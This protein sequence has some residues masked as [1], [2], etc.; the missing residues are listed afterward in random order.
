MSKT[1]A[2]LLLTLLTALPATAQR[3]ESSPGPDWSF[4]PGRV[5]G[6]LDYVD[7]AFDDA[8]F[9][10]NLN[11]AW[12]LMN[13]EGF[14]VAFPQYAWTDY[15]YDGLARFMVG[16]KTGFISGNGS[17]IIDAQYDYADRFVDGLAVVAIEDRW[18]VIDRRN[19]PAVPL[20][21]DGVL[22]FQDGFAAVE[23][24]GLCGFV[25]R[26]GREVV[27]MRFKSVRS[28]HNGFAAVQFPDDR[29]GYIDKRGEIVWFDETGRVTMLGDFHE[30]YAR[31]RVRMDNERQA[32]GYLT[33]AYRWRLEPVYEDARDFHNGVAAVRVDGKW[34]FVYPNGRWAIEPQFD[35]VDDFDDAVA[36][37][38]FEDPSG[39]ERE[40]ARGGRDR[41]PGRELRTIGLYAPV[42]IDGHWGYVNIAANAG[43][44]PQF[45]DA[46]PFYLGLARVPRGD[47]F[48][49]INETGGVIFDPLGMERGI[50][51][52][53]GQDRARQDRDREIAP[54]ANGREQPPPPRAQADVPY[55]PEYLYE[56]VL[57]RPGG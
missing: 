49:Y 55:E 10:I 38:D 57:P 6:P 34:G 2:V 23:R 30:Q 54:R 20:Q 41:R 7:P 8:L 11:N 44:V 28:F 52:R 31:V 32:W 50:I 51:N 37:N 36:S 12:G 56:E 16:G 29:W 17:V 18:G 45:E 24:E 39:H 48:A 26:R 25:D 33:R 4:P 27:P 13:Q 35:A 42:K 15:G 22:R 1:P 46:E 9:P 40:E 14:I 3:R 19:E 5:Y 53:T 47:S 43:I 21:Y